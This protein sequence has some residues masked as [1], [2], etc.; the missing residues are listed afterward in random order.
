M[1][2]DFIGDINISTVLIITTTE[3]IINKNKG[4]SQTSL[5]G[6]DFVPARLC[7][8]AARQ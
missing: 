6:R 5:P 4:W 8:L 3:F 7:N 2:S 1:C